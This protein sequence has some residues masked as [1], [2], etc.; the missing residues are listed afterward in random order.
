MSL[1]AGEI[2]GIRQGKSVRKGGPRFLEFYASDGIKV[3]INP[4]VRV[5]PKCPIKKGDL[6]MKA[7][8]IQILSA[9]G[10]TLNMCTTPKCLTCPLA[11]DCHNYKMV[12]IEYGQPNGREAF[13]MQYEQIQNKMTGI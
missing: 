1:F 5:H 3:S 4:D 9:S 2:I 11:P 6:P 13:N 10:Q 7:M 8:L 12:D